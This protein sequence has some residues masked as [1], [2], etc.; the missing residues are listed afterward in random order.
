MTGEQAKWLND[1]KARGFRVMGN[2]ASGAIYTEVGMLYCDGSYV[3][4]LSRN[5]RYPKIEQGAFEVGIFNPPNQ[6]LPNPGFGS[7]R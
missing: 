6:P 7:S 3:K 4:K 2:A 1:N 5:W